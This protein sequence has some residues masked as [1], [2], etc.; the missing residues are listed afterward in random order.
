MQRRKHKTIFFGV[1]IFEKIAFL[2][3]NQYK[4]DHPGDGL[5]RF[6]IEFPVEKVCL[7]PK[8]IVLC[9]RRCMLY[10]HEYCSDDYE[11]RRVGK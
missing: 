7:I 9:W 10:P 5:V 11:R 3:E 4:T 1:N 6:C 8:N 2:Q